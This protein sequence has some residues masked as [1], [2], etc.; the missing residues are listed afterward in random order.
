M[1]KLKRLLQKDI[2]LRTFWLLTACVVLAKA[3][4]GYFQCTYVW[5]GGA[6]L[7]D[8][9]MW[10]AAN[11]ITAGEWLGG[12]DCLTLSKQMFFAVWLALCNKLGV[13]YLVAGQL[14]LCGAALAMAWAFAP[15]LRQNKFRFLLFAALALSPAGAASF[16]LRVYRDNIFPSLCI[17]FFAGLI[18]C[19]LRY[20]GGLRH[21]WPWLTLAGVGLGLAKITR[22]D[23]IWLLPFALAATVIT[24]GHILREKGL[25]KKLLRCAAQALPYGLLACAV[26]VVSAVNYKHYGV[27]ATSDFSEGSFAAAYGAMTRIEHEN[28]QNLVPV[29]TDVREKLYAAVPQ[30]APLRYWLEEDEALQNSYRNPEQ[31]DYL[32]GSFYWALR[33]AAQQEGVYATAAGAEAYWQSVADAINAAVDSGVLT[34]AVGERSSTT[35]I[36]KGY[37][38]LPTIRE[39]LYSFGYCATF[40]DCLCYYPDQLSLITVEDAAIWQAYLGND[41]NYAAQPY[42]DIPSY[43]GLQR[44][45]YTAFNCLIPLYAVLV[46]VLLAW[47]VVRLVRGGL[48]MLKA[49]SADGL[50]LWLIL[51]GLLGMALLRCAMIAFMEVAAFNIGTY[52]MYLSTVHPLLIT[53]AVAGTLSKPAGGKPAGGSTLLS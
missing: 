38:V 33:Q 20:K 15:V 42:T 40:R 41:A 44:L 9:L 49:R 18:G 51:L 46:P 50:L 28:E 52:V 17:L 32:A 2:S 4:L 26:L 23:G 13:P 7:D 35:P 8:E 29:P 37:H 16:T 11:S 43:S 30:L 22:E 53:F 34:A 1:D 3:A 27:F 39:T 12:Y 21:Y 5:V 25:D 36:I 14:L 10:R 47:A 48:A 24:V 6:P 31:D 19:A 45:V